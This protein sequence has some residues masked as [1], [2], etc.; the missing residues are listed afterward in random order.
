MAAKQ[1]LKIATLPEPF[2]KNI[3]APQAI[4]KVLP[5]KEPVPENEDEQNEEAKKKPEEEKKIGGLNKS[6]KDA[7]TSRKSNSKADNQEPEFEDK[8]LTV[9]PVVDDLFIYVMHEVAIKE[10][11]NDLCEFV[12]KQFAKDLEIVEV[13]VLKE[14]VEEIGDKLQE[15][16]FE[17]FKDVPQFSF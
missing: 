7:N 8:V 14:K 12:K 6:K 1:K 15:A 17:R 5:P 16:F 10:I 13:D 9:K 4:V 11:R 3:M 2:D